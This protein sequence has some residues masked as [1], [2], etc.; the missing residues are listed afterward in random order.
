MKSIVLPVDE[1]SKRAIKPNDLVGIAIV[2]PGNNLDENGYYKPTYSGIAIE[3]IPTNVWETV[4][5]YNT[6]SY[7]T[8]L[9]SLP[10]LIQYAY[11]SNLSNKTFYNNYIEI[12][13]YIQLP[14]DTPYNEI[15]LVY[16]AFKVDSSGEIM[17]TYN[18]I[19]TCVQ[20][21]LYRLYNRE[22]TQYMGRN[23]IDL[24]NMY[25]MEAQLAYSEYRK[26]K[27]HARASMGF[28]N[29]RDHNYIVSIHNKN[30]LHEI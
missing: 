6:E 28:M 27:S 9:N 1:S 26:E 21:C 23:T 7:V 29:D 16:L 12:D 13:N 30:F 19:E 22:K 18:S 14:Y 17:L 24:Y 8:Q 25:V 20:F 11:S 10:E 3:E 2:D 4:F 5:D 15:T